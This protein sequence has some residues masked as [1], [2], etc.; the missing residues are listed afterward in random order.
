[1][2]DGASRRAGNT[3]RTPSAADHTRDPGGALLRASTAV[4]G[5]AGVLVTAVSLV[6]G[7]HAALAAA[8]GSVLAVAALAVGPLLLTA[9][10][11]A[12]PPAV[13]AA[14]AG[15]YAGVVVVLAIAFAVLAP[16]S[17]L[18]ATHLAVALV[19]VTVAGLAG[20]VR[21]VTQLRV[22]VFDPALAERETGPSV[23]PDGNGAQSSASPGH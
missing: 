13:T 21:A 8:I 20:Q 22:P 16:L 6:W 4:A 3:S 14:A 11:N 1:V 7:A 23:P 18:S 9:T 19:V 17:W 12:S 2:T 15:G 10:R 5:V